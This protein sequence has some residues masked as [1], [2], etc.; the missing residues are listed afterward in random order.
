MTNFVEHNNRAKAKKFAEYITGDTLRQ[1]VA[2]KVKQ[3][4]GDNPTVFDGA[5]GSGQLTQYINQREFV[6]VEIQRES[7]DALAQNYPHAQIYNQSFFL[8]E[9][10]FQADCVVMNPPFSMKFKDL[11]NH[12]KLAIMK[13]F[14]WKKS[15]VVDDVFILKSLDF[16][17]RYAVHICF[18]GLAYRKAEQRLRGEIGAKLAELVLIENGFD[19]TAISVLLLVIDK[20]KTDL[21]YQQQIYDC[22]TR[23]TK[24]TQTAQLNNDFDW[25]IPRIEP[26]ENKVLCDEINGINL[27]L[28][29]QTLTYLRA[30]LEQQL[31]IETVFNDDVNYLGFIADVQSMLTHYQQRYLTEKIA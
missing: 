10:D 30:H 26:T 9:H 8:F 25:E 20:Q 5:A 12:D 17:K 21:T 23:T 27:A 19:D 14:T 13:K 24:L 15:G 28:N 22:K 2:T 16:C 18:S 4:C 1:F 11:T 7:C 6:A 29:T 31:L 3:Y